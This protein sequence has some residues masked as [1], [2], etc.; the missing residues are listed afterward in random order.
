[1]Q[2]RYDKIAKVGAGQYG[3]VY[4]AKDKMTDATVALKRIALE[5]EDE[6]IPCTAIRE[7]SLLK[8]LRHDNVVRLH[9]V[10]HSDRKLTLV[11][12]F[13]QMDLRD[14]MDKHGGGL[15][16]ATVQ[17]FMRQ[18]LLGIEYCHYR[19]V[20]HRDLKPQ[21]LLIS[22]DRVLKLADFG[23]GR[24]FEIPVHR[25]THD[26]VTLWYRPPDVLLGSTKYGCNI[27][28]WSAGC[29]FAEMTTGKPVFAGRTDASQLA[30]IFGVLGWPTQQEWP[31]MSDCPNWA[32][33]LATEE[34]QVLQ[35]APCR[36]REYFDAKGI[37]S[38][39]GP[40]GIDLLLGMLRYEPS[41]RL[42]ASEALAHPYFQE[43]F[44]QKDVPVGASSPA[45]T[46]P[47]P[48]RQR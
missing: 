4:M 47:S 36:A 13:L 37:T 30:K 29:I 39:L 42:S 10:V 40:K 25:M 27:D 33:M 32:N 9:D 34:L 19:M 17:H 21:N 35:H 26:V 38:V 45:Q 23:L 18:L 12:E 48:L 15:D 24:A 7:I 41:A 5:S 20:L 16:A 31:T 43:R 3:T 8:E 11:F 44:P 2:N 46:Q 1:M 22:R 14:Y 28:I 6:G